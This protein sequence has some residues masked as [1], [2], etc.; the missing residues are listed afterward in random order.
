MKKYEKGLIFT[1][2]LTSIVLPFFPMTVKAQDSDIFVVGAVG[3]RDIAHWDINT[4]VTSTGDYYMWSCLEQL[5]TPRAQVWDGDVRN[6]LIPVLA[7]SWINED[8]PDEKNEAGF[9]SYNGMKSVEVTLRQGVKFHDGSDWNA[10]VCKWNIDRFMTITGNISG[11]LPVVPGTVR[12]VRDTYWLEVDDWVDYESPSWNVSKFDGIPAVYPGFGASGDMLS[13]FPRF[14]NITIT[15]DLQSGGK[16]KIYFGDW[17]TGLNYLQGVEMISKKSY[18][19]YFDTIIYGYGNNPAFPQDNPAIFPGH[20]IGTGPYVF[21]GHVS[22]IGTLTRFDDWWNASAQQAEGWHTIENV[23]VATFAHTQAGYQARST[24]M[25]TGDIDWAWDRSWEPLNKDDMNSAPDVDYISTGVESYGENIILNCI[26][27]TFMKT[28]FADTNYNMSP[29][30]AGFKPSFMA[31]GMM[32]ADDT[33]N[34]HGINR[35]FRKAI[36]YAFDYDTYVHVAMNDRV[37]RSGGFLCGTSP[38]YNGS[39]P[40]ATHNRTIAR[41]ALLDDPFWGPICADRQLTISNTT[42]QWNYIAD[43][44]PIYT[45]EYSWDQ[46]H[47]EAYSVMTTS[48]RDIGCDMD[49]WEDTP[50]SYYKMS[51]TFTFPWFITDGFALKLYYPRVNALGYLEAY[52][53]SPAS[54]WMP[55]PI[56]QFYNMGFSYSSTFDSIMKKI[57]FQNETGIQDSYNQLTDWIQNYQYPTIYCG[58]DLEG[59]AINKDYDYSFYWGVFVFNLVKP[60]EADQNPLIPGFSVGVVLPVALMAIAYTIIRKKRHI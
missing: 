28:F 22:D 59:H 33:I 52:Y 56:D 36:S 21:G 27:E 20:L 4:F 11:V 26:N 7:T 25:V 38:Y 41:Q 44:D 40:L 31:S 37:V 13:R 1:L 46:A 3:P 60:V 55:F 30:Y 5:F 23:A 6:E 8:R 50:D 35:A 14:Y 48:L 17:D 42:A 15:E 29:W 34:A 2:F 32:N 9:M 12:T 39:I 16:V 45:M 53:K 10:T 18:E 43:T 49:A 24:A 54:M 19:D 57:W 47:L 51:T 58:N